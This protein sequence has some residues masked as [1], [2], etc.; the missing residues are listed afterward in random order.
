MQGI[1]K[2]DNNLGTKPINKISFND[3]IQVVITHKWLILL[4]FIVSFGSTI[5]YVRTTPYIYESKVLLMRETATEKLPASIIGV[6]VE[7]E[8]LDKSQEMLLK[9]TTL[10]KEIQQKLIESHNINIDIKQLSE[11]LSLSSPKDT[12]NII[13]LT[14]KGNSPE[15]VQAIANITSETFVAKLSQF[16]KTELGQGLQFL[17]QQMEQLETK[18][19]ETEKALSNFRDKEGIVASE[20][21]TNSGGL[22]SKLGSIQNDLLQAE[23][24][25][26]LTKTQL[27]TIEKLIEEKKAYAKSAST[28]GISSQMDQI[29]EKIIDLQIELSNKLET[30]TDMHP[31]VIAIKKKIEAAQAQL[32]AEFNKMLVDTG[33]TSLDPISELQDLMKQYVTLSVSLKSMERRAT[34]MK[35]RLN[36]F[37]TE[38]PELASKQVELM[39]LQR[40]SRIYEQAYSTLTSK[41]EDMRLM[42]QMKVAGLKVVDPASL[43]NSPISPQVMQSLAMGA[44]LGLFLGIGLAFFLHYIDDTIN[45]EEDAQR[46]INLPVLGS[47]P[48]ITPYDIPESVLALKTDNKAE[49][50]KN[51]KRNNG[52]LNR[53]RKSEMQ[54]LLGHSLIYAP[55]NS[56]KSSAKEGYRNLS[57]NIQ[58]ASID[59]PVKSLLV[60]SSIPGEGKT[61]TASNLAITMAR[62]DMKVLLVDAD[63]RR[64]RLHRILNQNRQPGLTDLLMS[65]IEDNGHILDDFIHSTAI[66]N[67]YLLPCGSHISNMESLLAS[68]KMSDLINELKQRYDVIIIDSP[69]LLSVADS[70]ALGN[71]VDGVLLVLFSGKTDSKTANRSI[72]SL[73]RA[74][75]NIIGTVITDVDYAR[76]Y[77]YYRY[78]RYYYHYYHH[79]GTEDSKDN[80]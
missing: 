78:Y 24:D 33:N 43:P 7:T 41:Y 47:I 63:I 10:L 8:K 56:F 72:G 17:N 76:H 75:A 35:D 68:Q 11:W 50:S 59:K 27:Q 77:G 64:P 65:S 46:F 3:Y 71:K 34:L 39:Q 5:Y 54:S 44:L 23:N 25:A 57:V 62:P 40:Q 9:S 66:D 69:P 73:E 79:Y 28:S 53:K 67:L 60:T 13:Q 74:N 58:F 61:T 48:K 42:E 38:H 80:E 51:T 45:T 26:E 4:A 16:K 21:E 70:I 29:R 19:K 18:I 55:K 2:T 52:N 36:Q 1:E 22:L 37:R 32:D 15:Q 49:I 12:A 6:D 30:Q 14:A 31:E 20:L